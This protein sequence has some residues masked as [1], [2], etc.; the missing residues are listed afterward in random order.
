MTDFRTEDENED[1]LIIFRGLKDAWFRVLKSGHAI[2]FK[3]KKMDEV[4]GHGDNIFR[5]NEIDQKVEKTYDTHN[6]ITKNEENSVTVDSKNVDIN[7]K[8]DGE[9]GL[10]T[11]DEIKAN[12][13]V[14]VVTT[15]S[16]SAKTFMAKALWSLTFHRLLDGND[17]TI[18]ETVLTILDIIVFFCHI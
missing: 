5:V 17:V 15:N 2:D 10:I 16:P 12:L 3:V 9:K 6:N 7:V 14:L 11:K 8:R 18:K 13:G 4:R 1:M